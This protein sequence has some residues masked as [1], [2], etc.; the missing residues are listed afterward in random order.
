MHIASWWAALCRRLRELLSRRSAWATSRPESRPRVFVV[1]EG[2][3]D[4]EFLRTVT[5][6]C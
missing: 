3:Y 5:G 1:V 6:H 4:I 2:R